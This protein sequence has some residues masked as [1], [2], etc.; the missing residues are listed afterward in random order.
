MLTPVRV[1]DLEISQ[2]LASI[3]PASGP[4]D[5]A[6]SSALVL[7][8]LHGRPLGTL[9]LDLRAGAIA[10]GE[11][12]RQVWERLRQP[13]VDHLAADG[14]EPPNRLTETGL[15]PEAPLDGPDEQPPAGQ[16]HD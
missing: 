4:G 7:V 16:R 6:Y 8:R 2:P 13:I 5:V 14:V 3:G 15:A 11:V 9:Q 1:L 10:A 12:A